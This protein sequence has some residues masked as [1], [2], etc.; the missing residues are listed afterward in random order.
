MNTLI[1]CNLKESNVV[2]LLMI[3][4]AALRSGF[5]EQVNN[6]L[7]QNITGNMTLKKQSVLFLWF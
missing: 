7:K 5:V 1:H 4:Q 2:M 3:E 6:N